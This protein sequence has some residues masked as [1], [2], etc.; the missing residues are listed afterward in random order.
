MT[1]VLGQ[2]SDVENRLKEEWPSLLHENDYKLW[3]DEWERHGICSESILPQHVFFEAALKLKGKYRL[4]EMLAVKGLSLTSTHL[5]SNYT[6]QNME[7][8]CF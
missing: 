3:K 1:N 4:V 5:H 7:R 2:I 6:C 8:L